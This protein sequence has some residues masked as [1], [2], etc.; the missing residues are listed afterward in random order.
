MKFVPALSL[1]FLILLASFAVNVA[2]AQYKAN[3]LSLS[4]A[5]SKLTLTEDPVKDTSRTFGT[6][7]PGAGFTVADTKMGSMN[8]RIFSYIRYLNQQLLDDKYVNSFGDTST[9]RRRSD[10]QLNKVTVNFMGWLI[11]ERFRY[12]FYVWTNNTAQG[13]SAQVVVAGNL[14]YKFNDYF[15]LAGGI[16]ALPG[17]RTLE[18]NFPHWHSID[19]RVI[20]DEFFRP[21]YTTGFWIDGQLAKGFFYHGMIGNNLS[22]LGIDAG[23]LDASLST[24]S[25][26]LKWYPTTGE[27]G[28]NGSYGDFEE[29]KEVATR[30][31]GHLTGSNEDEESQ[32]NSDAFDNTQ[33]RLSDGS[34][35]FKPNLF[36]Q[37]INIKKAQYRMVNF[38]IGLKY[39][40]FSFDAGYYYRWLDKFGGENLQLLG[41]TELKD[42]GFLVQSSYMFIP[43]VLQLYAAYSKIFGN[44]GN[45]WEIAGG[46]NVYPWKNEIFRANLEYLYLDKSPVGGLSVPYLVGSTGSI[47]QLNL[48]V[49]F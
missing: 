3:S 22:Q 12:L 5:S 26:A 39:S 40:G 25:L 44:Y 11:D 14:S 9:L 46:V 31:A 15:R 45:P 29:H 24:I 41:F 23:Q 47:V 19:S 6:Y 42:D 1:L 8:L 21:S 34:L 4:T 13:Q 35:L 10:I 49:N 30:I 2:T 17:T 18:G 43:K 28:R 27:F 16:N 37:G 38:D 7:T 20:T 36:G 48:M 33:L 32:T